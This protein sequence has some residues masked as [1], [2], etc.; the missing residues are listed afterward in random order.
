MRDHLIEKVIPVVLVTPTPSSPRTNLSMEE[1]RVHMCGRAAA[2]PPPHPH[3]PLRLRKAEYTR[4]SLHCIMQA[5][6]RY[7][8][9]DNRSYS[10]S[11]KALTLTSCH[12]P[13][14]PSVTRA[15]PSGALSFSGLR[16]RW[17]RAVA[18]RG[19]G[20]SNKCLPSHPKCKSLPEIK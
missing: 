20:A 7:C 18:E 13:L 15:V 9:L 10:F 6:I 2:E 16:R 8:R 19:H 4:T 12:R 14:Q 11:Y 17:E 1:G 3:Q 5:T